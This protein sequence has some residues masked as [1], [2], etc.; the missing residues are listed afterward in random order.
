MLPLPAFDLRLRPLRC[1]A[2]QDRAGPKGKWVL[3]AVEFE[4]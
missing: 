4:T 1:A 2:R 3:T